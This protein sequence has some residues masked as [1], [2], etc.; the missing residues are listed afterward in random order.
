MF[1][2]LQHKVELYKI[3][4]KG[5]YSSIG[6]ATVCGTVGSLFKSGYPPSINGFLISLFIRKQCIAKTKQNTYIYLYK[7]LIIV[8]CKALKMYNKHF[9]F[10][11]G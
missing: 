11:P 10:M 7:M 4:I 8:K 9:K 2:S 3:I 5:G 6:R 1:E